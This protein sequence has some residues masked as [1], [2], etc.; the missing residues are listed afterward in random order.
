MVITVMVTDIPTTDMDMVTT[1]ARDPLMLKPRPSLRPL[2]SPTM[3]I[4]V[5]VTDIPTTDTDMA[6]I[7]TARDLLMP[8]P[9]PRPLLSLSTDIT[10]MV[11]T[12]MDTVTVTDT[13]VR[14][15]D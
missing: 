12:A 15:L 9:N 4:T 14:L 7:T 10:V 8:R 5:M 1:M 11:I 6:T 13:T 2:P 3:V